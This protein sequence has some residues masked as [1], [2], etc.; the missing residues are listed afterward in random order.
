MKVHFSLIISRWC[1]H[2]QKVFI[3]T[4]AMMT[5]SSGNIF[6]VTG[7]L[8]GN[9]AGHR[10][11]PLT[12][13]SGAKLWCFLG[14]APEQ[15]VEKTVETLVIWGAIMRIVT[16]LSWPNPDLLGPYFVATNIHASS[17]CIW[18]MET[19]IAYNI[20]L[21][22]YWQVMDLNHMGRCSPADLWRNNNVIITPKR[23]GDVVL[24]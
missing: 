14:C 16:L 22:C 17:K 19:R 2:I 10:W 11:I 18:C 9:S 5:S 13:A 4:Y 20:C 7:P 15:A 23:H 6:R 24:T 3:Q 8:W 21:F 1:W 12:K